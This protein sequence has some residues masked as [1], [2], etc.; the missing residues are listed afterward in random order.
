[1]EEKIQALYSDINFIGFYCMYYK[2]VQYIEK[3]KGLLPQIQEFV[4]WFLQGNGFGIKEEEYR[5]LRENLLEILRDC[6]DAIEQGDRVLLMDAM[7]QGMI[8]YL[9]LFLSDE[10]LKEKETFYVSTA[11]RKESGRVG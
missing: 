5:T 1:M 9:K 10:Y 2:D 7:E 3:I 4:Q 6:V 11:E 8:E